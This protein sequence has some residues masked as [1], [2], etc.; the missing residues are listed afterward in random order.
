MG[1]DPL[2]TLQDRLVDMA[3]LA[4]RLKAERKDLSEANTK[5]TFIQPILETL[6]WK[7]TDPDEVVLE[8]PVYG[9]T[10]LDYAL[11]A[12]GKPTLYLE[13][14]ALRASMD[15]P[16]FIAQTVSYAN[17][18][19]IRWCVLTNGLIWR[20]YKS[21]ALAPADQKLLA[22]A[23]IREATDSYGAAR[24]AATLAYLSKESL[25]SGKLDEWGERVFVDTAV[26]RTISSL[27]VQGSSRLVN[28]VRQN[29]EEPHSPKVIRES[30]LRLGANS[31]QE[32]DRT[33]KSKPRQESAPPKASGL[34]T[35]RASFD[36]EH[37]TK[38]KPEAI[39]DLFNKL[40]QR[41]MALG[42]DVE[43][44]FLKQYINYKV[45]RSFVTLRLDKGRLVMDVA[46]SIDECPKPDGLAIRDVSTLG[47]QGLGDTEVTVAADSDIDG[48]GQ[49]A[50]SS[51]EHSPRLE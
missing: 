39:V 4:A 30:L 47:H 38:G 29:L 22:E 26:R 43:R 25:V 17:N 27:L 40:D 42:P 9:G 20:I 10:R 15:E 18:D 37:H 44:V 46:L 50:R 32:G 33:A 7:V 45:K 2:R 49:V 41:L 5:V 11:L 1:Q 48:A 21:D 12:G 35:S 28:L 13:A 6:G 3:Q 31:P 16:N 19:G 34:E 23:D 24:V 14:K 8:Y 51:Y 36:L